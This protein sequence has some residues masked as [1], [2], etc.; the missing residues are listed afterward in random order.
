MPN[1]QWVLTTVELNAA[2]NYQYVKS[3]GYDKFGNRQYLAYGNGTLTSYQYDAQNLRMTALQTTTANGRLI[4]NNSYIYDAVGNILSLTNNADAVTEE[5]LYGGAT[6]SS[7]AYDNR[8]RLINA[9]GSFTGRD[10]EHKYSLAM[11]YGNTGSI[12]RKMQSNKFR[13]IATDASGTVEGDWLVDAE[14]SMDYTYSYKGQKPH[15]VSYIEDA[16]TETL[17]TYS[18]DASG[19]NLLETNSKAS[20]DREIVWTEDNRMAAI[21]AR[22]NVSHYIYDANGIRTLKMSS[23]SFNI[24]VNGVATGTTGIDGNFTV[25]ANPYTVVRENQCTKHFFLGTQR[26]LTKISSNDVEDTFY[27]GNAKGTV[28]GVDY[29]AKQ[30][31]LESSVDLNTGKLNIGWYRNTHGEVP[32]AYIKH[33]LRSKEYGGLSGQ[34]PWGDDSSSGGDDSDDNVVSPSYEEKQYYFHP[35]HPPKRR[36]GSGQ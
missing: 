2:N 10:K 25:Y 19:N 13:K 22:G 33:Y 5:H 28:G 24:S 3:I 35:D 7:Y 12:L 16:D 6:M 34:N 23:S 8:Y 15:A 1:R 21:K 36:T 4:Q 17:F 14:T 30:T 26:I 32:S 18:Y 29:G 27:E 31:A 20:S 11:E 9:E